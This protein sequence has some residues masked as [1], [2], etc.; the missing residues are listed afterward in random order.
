MRVQKSSRDAVARV[1]GEGTGELLVTIEDFGAGVGDDFS[2]G[3]PFGDGVPADV[4]VGFAVD[5]VEEF[6]FSAF[7]LAFV[8]FDDALP[9]ELLRAD[10]AEQDARPRREGGR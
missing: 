10:A 7:G 5:P 1:A 3:E 6:V 2:V 4:G 9:G 8:L